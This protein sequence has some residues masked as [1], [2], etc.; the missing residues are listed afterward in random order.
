MLVCKNCGNKTKFKSRGTRNQWIKEYEH[1]DFWFDEDGNVT[2]AETIDTYDTDYEEIDNEEYGD[3]KCSECDS[4]ADE[5]DE[6]EWHNFIEGK[7]EDEQ[8]DKLKELKELKNKM[9]GGTKWI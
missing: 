6:E 8:E 2:E 5:V 9:V 1:V 7:S 3:I 4:I